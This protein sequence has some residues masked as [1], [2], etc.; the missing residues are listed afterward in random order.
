MVCLTGESKHSTDSANFELFRDRGTFGVVSVAWNITANSGDDPAIDVSPVYGQVTFL[1][2]ESSKF[3]TIY[4]LP[5]G[6]S[7]IRWNIAKSDANIWED[8]LF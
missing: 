3:I 2:G 5:D 7:V 6:V 4:S 1:G 8:K